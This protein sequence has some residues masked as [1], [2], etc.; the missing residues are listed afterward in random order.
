MADPD[1]APQYTPDVAAERRRGVTPNSSHF[2]LYLNCDTWG[3][4][5]GETLAK[6]IRAARACGF[7]ICMIH[8]ADRGHVRGRRTQPRPRVGPRPRRSHASLD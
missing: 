8:E 5:A 4:E 3:G 1:G 6:E 7:P 2:V